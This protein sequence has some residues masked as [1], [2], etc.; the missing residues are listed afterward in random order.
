[1]LLYSTVGGRVAK[2]SERRCFILTT[3]AQAYVLARIRSA[4]APLKPNQL[5]QRCAA[6]PRSG[7]LDELILED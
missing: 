2:Q 1:M 3:Q 4:A 7:K 6:D 5:Q